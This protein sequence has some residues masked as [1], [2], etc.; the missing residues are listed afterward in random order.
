MTELTLSC[1]NGLLDKFLPILGSISPQDYLVISN[2]QEEEIVIPINSEESYTSQITVP[3]YAF[4]AKDDYWNNRQTTFQ[5]DRIFE[6]L[7]SDRKKCRCLKHRHFFFS[8]LTL[9]GLLLNSPK[10]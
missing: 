10:T 9:S 7:S 2:Y 3:Q 6:A 4:L 1:K 5:S 8:D